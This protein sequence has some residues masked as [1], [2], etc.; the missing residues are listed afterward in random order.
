MAPV[1]SSPSSAAG[2]HWSGPRP[3]VQQ[4]ATIGVVYEPQTLPQPLDIQFPGISEIVS[5]T[6]RVSNQPYQS[7]C[8]YSS[9]YSG[10]NASTG[11]EL[12]SYIYEFE[13][14]FD[15]SR[16]IWSMRFVQINSSFQQLY[17]LNPTTY[18]G[19]STYIVRI[20]G[21]RNNIADPTQAILEIAY[22]VFGT[23]VQ[24]APIDLTATDIRQRV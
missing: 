18:D 8:N 2:I 1:A 15:V 9:N 22:E 16:P 7:S 6:N 5:V 21:N 17:Y 19:A 14:K 12:G 3:T 11:W 13:V 4:A 10:L 23:P 24:S 20:E